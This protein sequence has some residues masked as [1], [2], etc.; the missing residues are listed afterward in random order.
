M[1]GIQSSPA[2]TK[3]VPARRKR[4]LSYPPPWRQPGGR[5]LVNLPQMPPDS[6]GICMIIDL[7]HHPFAPGLPPGWLGSPRCLRAS[8]ACQIENGEAIPR[9]VERVLGT[10]PAPS[11]RNP[12]SCFSCV[13]VDW[14]QPIHLNLCRNLQEAG[15]AR[16]PDEPNQLFLIC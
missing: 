6:G 9:E 7:R 11:K 13:Q 14:L 10:Q 1:H 12:T 16:V 15:V 5:S 4:H 2:T 8:L 3:G